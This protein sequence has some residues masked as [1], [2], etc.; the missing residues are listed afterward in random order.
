MA[1]IIDGK[2]IAQKIHEET[3]KEAAILKEKHNLQ[4]GLVVVLIGEDPAS[5]VYVNMKEKKSKELG[6]HSEKIVLD[7]NAT[8]DEVLKLIDKLNKDPKVHGILVQSPPPPQIDEDKVIEAID[9]RKDVDC[10]HAVNV[11]KMLIGKTDGFYPCTP[12]G[13]MKLLEYSNVNPSGKHAVIIG[14]SNIVGKPMMSL[15]VQKAKGADATVT[16]CHSRTKN[17][18]E[19]TLQGDIIIA[20]IGKPEFLKADM[21]KKGAV[22][23]D[24]GINRVEDKSA[25]TGYKLVGDV[26]FEEVSA[27]ASLITP[28]PGGVGPMTIAMLMQNTV[29]A[30]KIQ[31]G[32]KF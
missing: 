29:K 27:K 1:Q 22:V 28:V 6:F 4:P 24:V 9:H 16:V 10:F 18:K 19:Y 32:I 11:G 30:C 14:R 17:M 23:I 25:K 2:V 31:N 5:Q 7:K 21:V 3:A 12:Y 20:A 15:L 13:I 26:A 8:M